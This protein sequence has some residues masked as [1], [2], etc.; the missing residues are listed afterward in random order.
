MRKVFSAFLFTLLVSALFFA[1]LFCMGTVQA[2]STSKKP[3]IPEFTLNIID[4]PHI[5]S[6]NYKLVE[7]TIKNQQYCNLYA[8]R[9]K[10]SSGNNWVNITHPDNPQPQSESAY[11]KIILGLELREREGLV[12][13]GFLGAKMRVPIDELLDIQVEAMNGAMRR[14]TEFWFEGETSGWSSTQ[15]ISLDVFTDE[16]PNQPD[17]TENL[18]PEPTKPQIP[19][20]IAGFTLTDFDFVIVC[21]VIVVLSIV[22]VYK[23]RIKYAKTP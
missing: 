7:I 14:S 15:T 21:V 11:T 10:S 16:V 13:I 22:L 1:G 17:P 6:P 12:V 2:Q 9:A 20:T 23:G 4:D 5:E 3:A 18:T 19:P 8:I